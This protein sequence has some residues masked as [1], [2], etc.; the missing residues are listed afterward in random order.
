MVMNTAR[1]VRE[2]LAEL[3]RLVNDPATSTSDLRALLGECKTY[4]GQLTVLQADAAA[5]LAV[6]ERHG[7]GGVGVLAQAVGLS[8]RDAA[9]QVKTAKQ[10]EALPS[11]RDAVENGEISVA[12]ARVLA[13]T[14][15]KTGSE[16]VA[17]D[18]ELLAKAAVLSP[19]QLAREA[20][21]WAAQRQVDGGEERY[22]RQRARRRLS[23]FD[24]DDGMVLVR[25]ELDPVT[26]A[27][28]RKRFLLEAERL[29]RADL[30][31]DGAKRS[32]S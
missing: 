11:V 10:L 2:G 14:S 1:R 22:R 20:G 5:G 13:G 9:G 4:G 12:N 24:G 18:E 19:E 15:D 17:Q 16:Q 3:I 21:R 27:K 26:G 8:R 23:I 6:R 29:R 7:D 25:G 32:L 30:H 31:S 28:V